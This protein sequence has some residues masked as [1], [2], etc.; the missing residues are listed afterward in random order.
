MTFLE[1]YN[2]LFTDLEAFGKYYKARFNTNVSFD[3]LRAYGK[4][5]L[6]SKFPIIRGHGKSILADLNR[7]NTINEEMF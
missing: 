2:H 5:C 7:C 4:D 1:K 6:N 3:E